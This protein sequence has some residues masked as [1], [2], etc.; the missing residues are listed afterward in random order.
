MLFIGVLALSLR[1]V[2]HGW[3]LKKR[4]ISLWGDPDDTLDNTSTNSL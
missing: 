3:L 2:V 1:A 4:Y